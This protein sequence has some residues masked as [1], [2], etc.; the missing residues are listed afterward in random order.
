MI[1]DVNWQVV[2]L[3]FWILISLCMISVFF[4]GDFRRKSLLIIAACFAIMAVGFVVTTIGDLLLAVGLSNRDHWILA[5]EFRSLP[6][7]Y[8][9]GIGLTVI[10]AVLRYGHFN[11]NK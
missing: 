11:G 3:D 10:A 1:I 5:R 7:R 9:L 8:C 4:A 6:L 2:I